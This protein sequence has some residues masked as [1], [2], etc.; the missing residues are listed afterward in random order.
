QVTT[1]ITHV[2]RIRGRADRDPMRH[3]LGKEVFIIQGPM[4][5]YRGTLQSL[6]QDT[7]EV[8]VQGRKQ[9]FLR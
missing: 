6:S 9:E 4:K 8:A 7:C 1:S 3:L 5:S 2:A